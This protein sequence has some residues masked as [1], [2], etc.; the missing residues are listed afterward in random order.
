MNIDL[1]IAEVM[2]SPI[3]HAGWVALAGVIF[4][5]ARSPS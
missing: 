3:I 1:T 4:T 5:R 2:A